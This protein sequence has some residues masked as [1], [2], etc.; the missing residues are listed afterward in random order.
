LTRSSATDQAPYVAARITI[1]RA[2]LA[3][4]AGNFDDARRHAGSAIELFRAIGIR[5]LAPACQ[6]QLADAELST[7]K[8]ANALSG[9]L[10]V[11]AIL[12][13]MGERRIRSTIQALLARVYQRIG[14]PVAARAATDLAEELSGTED[15]INFVHTHAVRARLALADADSDAAVRWAQ[16][17]VEQASR[18][19]VFT[20]RVDAELELAR[21]LAVLGRSEDEAGCPA[22]RALEV[23]KAK[24]TAR[25]PRRRGPCS[26]S[27]AAGSSSNPSPTN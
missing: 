25:G 5:V 20:I 4:L 17:A 12:G 27:C 2:E 3:R 8:P 19:G 26:R 24:A 22:R 23:S 18:T 9:L 16:S 10:E 14:H 11:D 6:Q 15:V 13:G 21:V 7:G 1:G